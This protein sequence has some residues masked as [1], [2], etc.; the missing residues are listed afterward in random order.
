M[1]KFLLTSFLLLAVAL[2]FAQNSWQ[3][4]TGPSGGKV[5]D[6][7]NDGTKIFAYASDLQTIYKSTDDGGSWAQFSPVGLP[8]L[9]MLVETNKVFAIEQTGI[10]SY[11]LNT[12][13]DNGVTWQKQNTSSVMRGNHLFRMAT[14]ELIAWGDFD[15]VYISFDDGVNWTKFYTPGISP[16]ERIFSVVANSSGDIFVSSDLGG[17]SR[18]AHAAQGQWLQTNFSNKRTP[19]TG[20]IQN[21]GLAVDNSNKLYLIEYYYDLSSVV[22]NNL[23]ESNDNGVSWTNITTNL[24]TPN[25][26]FSQWFISSSGVFISHGNPQ[27]IYKA[28]GSP[29]VTSWAEFAIVP[30]IYFNYPITAFKFV[31]GTPNKIFAGSLV[32]GVY[33]APDASA[34]L[35]LSANWT[36]ATNGINSYDGGDIKIN[37][38]RIFY[39]STAGFGFW[40]SDDQGASWNFI[41][42]SSTQQ[43][44]EIVVI[45]G[46]TLIAWGYGGLF[47]STDNGNNWISVPLTSFSQLD[48]LVVSTGKL[49]AA[50][51]NQVY[52]S[53]D[54]GDT[55]TVLS[56]TSGLP[57]NFR[58]EL[59]YF[60]NDWTPAIAIDGT[61]KLYLAL[62]NIDLNKWELYSVPSAGGA[63]TKLPVGYS[64]DT[65]N[66]PN[67]FFAA[68]NKIYWANHSSIFL[69]TDNGANW[70]TVAFDNQK[71]M[72]ITSGNGPGI[73]ASRYG[74]FFTSGDDGLTW[75]SFR[76]PNAQQYSY[77]R[78]VATN[79]S[80]SFAATSLA[81]G[82]KYA[83]PLVVDP[84][85]I[86]PYVNFNW[87]PL[88]GPSG[89]DFTKV[90][91]GS[92][93]KFF[94]LAGYNLYGTTS[95]S[96]PWSK[97]Q[98]P[99]FYYSLL[100]VTVDNTGKFYGTDGY[101]FYTSNNEGSSWT[102]IGADGALNNARLIIRLSNG[103]LLAD[104]YSNI[105]RSIDQGL[106]WSTIYSS[107]TYYGGYPGTFA[108]TNLPS[109]TLYVSESNVGIKKSTNNGASWTDA[110]TGLP[111]P[112]TNYYG[113]TVDQSG[114][115]IA[116]TY[117]KI[118]KYD[119]STWASINNNLPVVS[120]TR[121][122]CKSATEY[123]LFGYQGT[124]VYRTTDGGTVWVKMSETPNTP[125]ASVV[126]GS[127]NE[128]YAA[129]SNEGF[130]YSTNSGTTWSDW[131]TGVN[132]LVPYNIRMI[133]NQRLYL[134]TG[135]STSYVSLD[136]GNTWSKTNPWLSKIFPMP[137]GSYLA[138]GGNNI[139][140][141]TD[142]GAT[143]PV[144][145]PNTWMTD[146]ATT[147]GNTL[148]GVSNTG[149]YTKTPS[150]AWTQLTLSGLPSSYGPLQ[151][152][153][154]DSDNKFYIILFNNANNKQELYQIAFG[155]A[156]K[157]N[158]TSNPVSIQYYKGKDGIGRTYAF[159]GGGTVYSTVD[160]VTWTSKA[161]PTG[162]K[163]IIGHLDYFFILGG[164]GAVWLSRDLGSTWQNVGDSNINYPQEFKD[165][166]LNPNDGVVYG[167]VR[168]G[169]QRKSVLI[170][171]AET[172]APTYTL[173]SPANGD[174]NLLPSFK[175]QITFSEPVNPVAGKK[176]KIV[177]N[178]GGAPVVLGT[179]DVTLGAMNGNTFTFN[180][181]L[182]TP[183]VTFD[184]TKTYFISI[185]PGAFVDVNAVPN[186]FAG[187]LNTT[188]PNAWRFSTLANDGQAPVITTKSPADDATG[189]AYNTAIQIT[190]D[191]N[192]FAGASKT[193]RLYES[194][195]TLVQSF[196]ATDGVIT[197]GKT[198]TFTPTNPLGNGKNYYVLIDAGAY[199][200]MFGNP[201]AAI[202]SS[203]A[204]NFTALYVDDVPPAVTAYSPLNN[205]TGIA[206][207]TTLQL[208][209]NENIQTVTGKTVRIYDSSAPSTPVE[210]LDALTGVITGGS[211]VSYTLGASLIG[212]K[213][214]YVLVDAGAIK[215]L[216]GNQFA[217]IA[218]NTTWKFNTIIVD[219]QAPVVTT[220]TPA[221]NSTGVAFSPTLQITFN[222]DI[223]TVTGKT[224]RIYDSNAPAAPIE[225]IDALTGTITG[226]KTVTY[227]PSTVLLSSKTYFILID[228]GAIKDL[229]GNQ[230]AGIS[231]S[232]TWK[233][234]T[235]LGDTQ[236]PVVA[237]LA[238][239]NNATSVGFSTTLQIT[240]NENIQT[241][242]GKSLKIYDLNA[243]TNP[244]ETIDGA[245]GV[246]TTG[247]TVTF[248]P[249]TTLSGSKT[250][251]VL[252]DPGMIIDLAGNAYGGISNNTSWRFSTVIVDT[253]APAI[254]QLVPA[255]NETNVA[256]SVSLTITFN[257]NIKT[258]TG[259]KIKFFDNADTS[260][261]IE[262]IDA[263]SGSVNGKA[264]MF[265]L[266]QLLKG[267][268]T[269]YVLIE[270]GAITDIS[271]NAFGGIASSSVWRFSTDAKA[272][273]IV[274]L[275]PTNNSTDISATTSLVVQFDE[276]IVA[277]AGKT[278]TVYISG[279]STPVATLDA[280][281]ATVSGKTATFTL[282]TA[283]QS[284][285][286]YYVRLD[287]GSFTDVSG[288][289]ALGIN[290]ITDW[291]FTTHDGLPPVVT[292]V[293]P[294]N[295]A[296]E[297]S[298]T[299]ALKISF[300]EAVN[301]VTGK[302][303]AVYDASQ[304]A[305]PIKVIDVS[306]SLQTGNTLTFDPGTIFQYN[307][308]YFVQ[309]ESGAVADLAGNSYQGITSNTAW[310]FSV[311]TDVDK[312]IITYS[313]GTDLTKGSNT[314]LISAQIE[315]NKKVSD[316]KV[317]YRGISA[318]STVAFESKPL[319]FNSNT[320]KYEFSV[321]ETSF[322]KYGL[323]YYLQATDVAGNTARSPEDAN[324]SHYSYLKFPTA[325]NPPITGLAFGGT[326]SS[327]RII[328]IPYA[329]AD[330]KV[331]TILG[332]LGSPNKSK[333]RFLT[334]FSDTKWN[335]Y[336]TDFT[337]ID[338]GVGYWIN[339][340][341]ATDIYIEG[342]STDGVNKNALFSKTLA[343]GWNQIGNPYP[344]A[345]SW[346]AIKASTPSLG[347]IKLYNGG[348]INGDVLQPMEGGFVFNS[349]TTPV[350]VSF[351][352][353]ASTGGRQ[354]AK[355]E[356]Q[357]DAANWML[358]L[359]MTQDGL[360][361]SLA[362]VGMHPQ[363][364]IGFD[365]FDDLN[366]PHFSEYAQIQ[367]AHPQERI[368]MFARDVVPTQN[369]FTWE[370]DVDSNLPG[371]SEL[372]WDN[373]GF[374]DNAKEIYLYDVALEKP[375]D[376]RT[377]NKY[378]FDPK[379]SSH[380]K[381]IYGDNLKREVKP[382]QISLGA[383]YPN[384]AKT[385]TTIPFNLAENGSTYSVSLEVFDALGKKVGTL[386]EGNFES[387]FYSA[388]WDLQANAQGMYLVRLTTKSNK[389][390][391]VRSEKVMVEK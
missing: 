368:K 129:A 76:I 289:A 26:Y 139:Y 109:P 268:K 27:K 275:T 199:A 372:Y 355:N 22:H 254:A 237:L 3:G 270:S 65:T 2:T 213:T 95:M 224:L 93:G 140:K 258:V 174:V 69:S 342:A 188:G 284:L 52:S 100:D 259:K 39:L 232:T 279:S 337:T 130:Y 186:P 178:N 304:P 295:N 311:E 155:S 143:W 248:T 360:Q 61:G 336:P 200:D 206:L 169:Q 44:K 141:S 324:S 305:T 390:V 166:F 56:I 92:T 300:D 273:A 220:F 120:I 34:N 307:K 252:I 171:P 196:N 55:W 45:S 280:G 218:N 82:L 131:T 327:Y 54:L 345:I 28:S 377:Q 110:S 339:V 267:T 370:F 160:G 238:P 165:V 53:T 257:E 266:S 221:N 21:M 391:E 331:A 376:M 309:F 13:V 325:S 97:I 58:F 236:P 31:P 292:T 310:Q 25:L 106:T 255:N 283:L 365:Q 57:A 20:T 301:K 244:V 341:D 187:L 207:S 113:V 151:T 293:D 10:Q 338:R 316:A 49:F 136:K 321:P 14:G 142:G 121:V 1:K 79:G 231:N 64:Y 180:P 36:R 101:R 88:A 379:A 159:D 24:P 134:T 288:N 117:D 7:Q 23:F 340:K 214:Y 102:Q 208:T 181:A 111:D 235:I 126:F 367:F 35:S 346:K 382:Q 176:I 277:G 333:W 308:S 59:G 85:T 81:P 149:I 374:G 77:V 302:K 253:Q 386:I 154:V 74:V 173:L 163:F 145:S 319:I 87:T 246:I 33:R 197:S 98:D 18:H 233:F 202:T 96:S 217:G 215:D 72:P 99:N 91:Q 296:T 364:Q 223:Q 363:A 86:P 153:A 361:Y 137:D 5:T 351:P 312:P 156:Y 245:V 226:G 104:G 108:A 19:L 43:T 242:T 239:L 281:Q 334:Y 112:T 170:L 133:N 184:F 29:F 318:V 158:F 227:T 222:E 185:D 225:T 107:P 381:I 326:R 299:T 89:G 285:T 349:G 161:T 357:L 359:N 348:F 164:N 4:L 190:F 362:G 329:L 193:I 62:K 323:E 282:A 37:A 189:V 152:I 298:L 144:D 263:S 269:Y 68:G 294:A 135:Y 335:E 78:S 116:W 314:F 8:I 210:T 75:N 147:D 375:I 42:I 16:Y 124:G 150:T 230:Y 138:T 179:L 123:Y 94:A 205:A 127:G 12:T 241:V 383:A 380:F 276:N 146:I 212:S 41:Q 73:G 291:T 250:Y 84:A 328:S 234:S 177:D 132:E 219:T 352:L 356:T 204:W 306:S 371:L 90:F 118:Y 229:A 66:S 70:K 38:G 115:A 162:T 264:V 317:F 249:L 313:G 191:E 67:S 209:F 119:G 265:T 251:Y 260:N 80:N 247:K 211:T 389:V 332:E 261:P 30:G 203:S 183:V 384:P 271:N 192:I 6:I 287:D 60:S 172:T 17:V 46:T 195:S 343:P 50:S 9:A 216:T 51:Y 358:D 347:E 114:N 320:S 201:S 83:S 71:L 290:T 167:A 256:I 369:S 157:Q 182:F 194:P 272:P 315:D 387:G 388:I 32:E 385:Q 128:I 105:R 122:V 353:A 243:P 168:G 322:D 240:F 366:P 303:L 278:L 63:A 47:R 297:V 262:T 330:N 103:D 48:G 148:Y 175:L 350:T 15:G 228:A 125:L 198:V 373:T 40:Y 11:N 286:S 354:G 274:Q 344:V 378:A